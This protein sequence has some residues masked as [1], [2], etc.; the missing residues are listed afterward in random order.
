[1]RVH[2]CFMFKIKS[3][4]FFSIAAQVHSFFPPCCPEIPV[5][6]KI[7][8]GRQRRHGDGGLRCHGHGR[9]RRLGVGGVVAAAW[10]VVV[11]AAADAAA[12]AGAGAAARG[13]SGGN[14]TGSSSVTVGVGGV[15]AGSQ[16][17]GCRSRHRWCWRRSEG[18]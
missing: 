10:G 5:A 15:A 12:V 6:P 11:A 3:T 16:C 4:Q 18:R 17:G 13:G 7:P 1:M 14:A 2:I 8:E 9:R